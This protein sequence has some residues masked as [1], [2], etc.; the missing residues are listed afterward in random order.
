MNGF[1]LGQPRGDLMHP[2]Y[3]I[4]PHKNQ[5]LTFLIQNVYV[6][7]RGT[8]GDRSRK[9]LPERLYDTQSKQFCAIFRY[10]SNSNG[11]IF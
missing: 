4:K 6:V 5:S 3:C 1:P 10:L 7:K 11:L 9:M 8:A 2:C